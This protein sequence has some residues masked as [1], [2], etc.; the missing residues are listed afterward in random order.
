MRTTIDLPEDIHGLARQLA[1]DER[2]SV[3]EVI[4][5]LIRSGLR[6]P[7]QP[8]PTV[9]GVRG[10]PQVSVGRPVTADDVRALDDE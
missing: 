3:S 1:H 8:A 4:V 5:G 2:R 7:V 6:G 9:T 10:M